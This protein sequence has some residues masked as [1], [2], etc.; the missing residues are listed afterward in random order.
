M[1][2]V[3]NAAL[4]ALLGKTTID[5]H[6]EILQECDKALKKSKNDANSQH[7]KVVALLKL[8]RYD[9]AIQ[10]IESTDELK[11]KA[12]FEYAY[13]LYKNGRFQEAAETMS[14]LKSHRGAQHVEAQA[15]YRIEQAARASEIYKSLTATQAAGEDLD[16]RVNLGAVDALSQWLGVVDARTARRPGREDLEAFETAYNA[17]CGSV[18]RGELTQ[19]EVLLKRAK[20]LCRH[21]EDL[22]DEQKAEELLPMII[23]HIYVLQ[24]LGK[25]AEA[26]AM[27]E[28]VTIDEITDFA[29]RT[30]ALNNSLLTPKTSSNPFLVHKVFFISGRSNPIKRTC[31]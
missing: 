29:T 21:S 25:E 8:D 28:E 18:A 30:I 27:M 7:S 2:A 23:Q 5:D 24:S 20:E 22:S 9:E 31:N 17:A 3:A 13:A 14:Q 26:Q 15:R 6:Q 1:A 16:L 4:S 12:P 19:A 10:F 11:E